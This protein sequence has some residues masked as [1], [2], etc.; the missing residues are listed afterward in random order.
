MRAMITRLPLLT[1]LM[2]VVGCSSA[3][4]TLPDDNAERTSRMA[5]YSREFPHTPY[6][7]VYVPSKGG[8][9]NS[10]TLATIR[11]GVGSANSRKLALLLRESQAGE[12]RVAVTSPDDELAAETLLDALGRL[13]GKRL[14]GFHISFIGA[15]GYE[16]K[17]RP[18]VLRT[19]ATFAYVRH[20][21]P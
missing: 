13:D 1:T 20:S 12:A 7:F 6:E 14:E 8:A 17:L 11:S 19:G 4:L 3:P 18:A 21:G 10:V 9:S 15:S 16:E 2:V 5:A